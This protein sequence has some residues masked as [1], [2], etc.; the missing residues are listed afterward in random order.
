MSQAAQK[1][2]SKYAAILTFP[3]SGDLPFNSENSQIP[4]PPV[5]PRPLLSLGALLANRNEAK[6]PS[7][8]KTRR[9]EGFLWMWLLTLAQHER[10]H[11]RRKLHA[12]QSALVFRRRNVLPDRDLYR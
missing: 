9:V 5:C 12:F 2:A 3:L 4:E 6:T 10:L 1:K 11:R 8:E 7:N